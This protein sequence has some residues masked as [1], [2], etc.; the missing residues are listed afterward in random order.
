MLSLRDMA[1]V[2]LA[3]LTGA[4]RAGYLKGLNR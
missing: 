2:E 3:K 4:A 1:L